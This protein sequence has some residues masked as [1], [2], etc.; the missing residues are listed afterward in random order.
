MFSF[1]YPIILCNTALYF[2]AYTLVIFCG[3]YLFAVI[4]CY[5][6]NLFCRFFAIFVNCS[7]DILA[8]EQFQA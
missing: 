6:Q 5:F 7:L 3:K 8:V 1:I 2:F 4:F